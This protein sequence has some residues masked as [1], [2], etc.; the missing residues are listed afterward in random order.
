MELKNVEFFKYYSESYDKFYNGEYDAKEEQA[1]MDEYMKM[2]K[3]NEMF[4]TFVSTMAQIRGDCF[5]SDR[6]L[7]SAM[8]AYHLTAMTMTG[9]YEETERRLA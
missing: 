3:D 7:A 4:R 1:L 2:F 5:T 8:K 9:R 6:E